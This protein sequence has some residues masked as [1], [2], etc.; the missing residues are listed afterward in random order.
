MGFREFLA[1]LLPAK[2]AP[3]TVEVSTEKKVPFRSRW[4]LNVAFGLSGATFEE[5]A[6]HV[7]TEDDEKV[8]FLAR[9]SKKH[10]IIIV[11]RSCYWRGNERWKL[12]PGEHFWFTVED[13]RTMNQ[14]V[15]GR[16]R[17]E[18]RVEAE[19]A[20]EVL[21]YAFAEWPSRKKAKEAERKEHFRALAM[22]K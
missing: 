13:I 12:R 16:V 5:G 1:G 8:I 4:N 2:E 9:F 18:L 20:L 3:G 17:P 21:A 19:E 10:G 11:P 22:N 15:L 14:R 6:Y 7:V